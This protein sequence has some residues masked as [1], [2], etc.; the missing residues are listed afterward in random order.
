MT[1]SVSAIGMS[2]R[3]ELLALDADFRHAISNDVVD[4][5]LVDRCRTCFRR[6]GEAVRSGHADAEISVLLRRVAM[7]IHIVSTGLVNLKAKEEEIQAALGHGLYHILG[8]GLLDAKPLSTSFETVNPGSPDNLT[9]FTPYRQWFLDHFLN[10][11]PSS[12][13]KDALLAQVTV[14]TR[15][16]L[17]TWYTNQRRRSG[18][19]ALRRKYGHISTLLKRI[20]EADEGDEE[21]REAR[22]EI[23]RVRAYFKNDRQDHVRDEIREIVCQG[24]PTTATNRRVEAGAAGRLVGRTQ[25]ARN[26]FAPSFVD[27]LPPAPAPPTPGSWTPESV[28]QDDSYVPA[29]PATRLLPAPRLPSTVSSTNSSRRSFSNDSSSSTDSLI[30]YDS[31]DIP[32]SIPGPASPP[33]SSSLLNFDGRSTS[34]YSSPAR[35]SRLSPR[36]GS[37]VVRNGLYPTRPHPYFCTVNELPTGSSLAR[38]A[39]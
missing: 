1:I 30:S 27:N 11:Y 9:T 18:W 3:H 19:H 31:L 23:E 10:P 37:F 20:D 33:L 28:A 15:R 13:D 24:P 6:A 22:W 4:G 2:L 8:A 38:F 34:V 36:R 5:E 35:T 25:H 17:D 14:H 16:Q 26:Q 29:T 39:H 7:A 21:M 32:V 12:K